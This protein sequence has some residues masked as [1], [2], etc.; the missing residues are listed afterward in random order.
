VFLDNEEDADYNL[1]NLKYLL[2]E[3]I[4]TRRRELEY[5]DLRLGNKVYYKYK[6]ALPIDTIR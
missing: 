1:S 3:E 6:G 4:Q 5:V 2:D